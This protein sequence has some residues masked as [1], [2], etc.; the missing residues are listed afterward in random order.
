M[1]KITSAVVSVMMMF[2]LV[3]SP[4]VPVGAVQ[5]CSGLSPAEQAKCGASTTGDDQTTFQDYI[6]TIVNILLFLLGAIAVIM[7]IIGGIRYATSNGEAQQIK[8]A[9]D[10]ILYSVIGLVVAILSY[11]IVNFII[12]SFSG[13]N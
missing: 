8:S 10:T 9:K 2:G 12:D 11:A 3:A 5:D 13:S 6:K 4:V 7:I 1:K